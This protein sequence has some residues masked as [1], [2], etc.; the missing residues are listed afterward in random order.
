MDLFVIFLYCVHICFISLIILYFIA[1]ENSELISQNCELIDLSEAEDTVQSFLDMHR[2]HAHYKSRLSHITPNKETSVHPPHSY[3]SGLGTNQSY[4]SPP[5]A[6]PKGGEEKKGDNTPRNMDRPSVSVAT[7]YPFGEVPSRNSVPPVPFPL[8]SVFTPSTV[9]LE[10][11]YDRGI[12]SLNAYVSFH[13]L[14]IIINNMMYLDLRYALELSRISAEEH[15]RRRN[16]R[17]HIVNVYNG[18]I[19]HPTYNGPNNGNTDNMNVGN[20]PQSPSK[21]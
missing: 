5:G 15:E 17:A 12:L 16:Y 11:R 13:F 19:Y 20:T 6:F 7:P 8:P 18:P 21:E 9:E 14:T 10:E 2:R 3:S 4:R 1:T